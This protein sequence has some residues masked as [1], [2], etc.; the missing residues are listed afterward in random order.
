[1]NN[2]GQAL[3][4]ESYEDILSLVE[5]LILM[6]NSFRKHKHTGYEESYR[7]LVKNCKEKLDKE[8]KIH[9][10]E[11]LDELNV[12]KLKDL[13]KGL[14]LRTREAIFIIEYIEN[15][16]SELSD[17]EMDFINDIKGSTKSRLSAKQTTWLSD[18]YGKVYS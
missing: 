7:R 18:I 12:S 8:I 2:I 5:D 14:G 13:I 3:H 17:N 4:K 10:E 16:G 9:N 1:M 6:E 11:F 15:S